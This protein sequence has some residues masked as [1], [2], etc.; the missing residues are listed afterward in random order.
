MAQ[1]APVGPH[2]A[3]L[4]FIAIGNGISETLE[5]FLA[6]ITHALV[7][8][9]RF[10]GALLVDVVGGIGLLPVGLSPGRDA[11]VE[12]VGVVLTAALG[13]FGLAVEYVNR[14][15][16]GGVLLGGVVADDPAV[17]WVVAQSEFQGSDYC[18]G[19]GASCFRVT[20]TYTLGSIAG[21]GRFW[22]SE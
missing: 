19:L 13:Q 1:S 21:N 17:G 22:G 20:C 5:S 15:V 11:L 14:E 9:P 4:G 8:F 6:C 2:I 3:V 12:G 16:V 7:C 18:R 10:L